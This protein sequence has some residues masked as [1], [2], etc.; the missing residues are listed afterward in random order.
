MISIISR[1]IIPKFRISSL[2]SIKRKESPA[3][4]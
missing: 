3:K 2:S 1:T 4:R